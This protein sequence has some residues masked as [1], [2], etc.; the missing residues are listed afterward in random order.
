MSHPET[1]TVIS[2]K[3]AASTARAGKALSL[4]F[5]SRSL[6]SSKIDLELEFLAKEVDIEREKRR[7]LK[8]RAAKL[9]ELV[10]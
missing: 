6:A 2:Y 1:A 10:E 5:D 4:I 9:D 8:I 3:S 7:K